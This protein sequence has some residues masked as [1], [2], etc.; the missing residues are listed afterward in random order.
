MADQVHPGYGRGIQKLK[1]PFH[2]PFDHFNDHPPITAGN[3]PQA[4]SSRRGVQAKLLENHGDTVFQGDQ[5]ALVASH[6]GVMVED[7]LPYPLY[8]FLGDDVRQRC[9]VHGVGHAVLGA[10]CRGR[11]EGEIG[12][13]IGVE[14]RFLRPIEQVHTAVAIRQ[15]SVI[16]QQG[17]VLEGPGG[18]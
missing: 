8:L 7:I 9:N 17:H 4:G 13:R 5:P 14:Y 6:I 12:S 10:I 1:A 16:I 18:I 11:V 2:G 15:E 3:H